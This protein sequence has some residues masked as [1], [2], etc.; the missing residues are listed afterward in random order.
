[1]TSIISKSAFPAAVQ[2]TFINP[3]F[4][5]RAVLRV[6]YIAPV[7]ANM[8]ADLPGFK[9]KTRKTGGVLRVFHQERMQTVTC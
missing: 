1:V 6:E 9:K 3:G 5:L 4:I 2:V 7:L 8:V